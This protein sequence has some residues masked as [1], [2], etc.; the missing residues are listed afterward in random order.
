MRDE[1]GMKYWEPCPAGWLLASVQHLYCASSTALLMSSYSRPHPHLSFVSPYFSSLHLPD[2]PIYL[3]LSPPL[4]ILLGHPWDLQPL[5]F[6]H[7][8]LLKQWAAQCHILD[9]LN[10]QQ[11]QCGNCNLSQLYSHLECI[12]YKFKMF[13]T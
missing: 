4:G 12:K 5:I 9:S 11:N 2:R 10:H 13:C 8:I 1:G 7:Y 3:H 6:M